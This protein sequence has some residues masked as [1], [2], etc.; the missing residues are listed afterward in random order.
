M[1]RI[2]LMLLVLGMACGAALFALWLAHGL[3]TEGMHLIVNDNEVHLPELN[4]IH[5]AAGGLALLLA[6][7]IVALVLPLT[8]LL[9]LLLPL[10]LVLGVVLLIGAAALG[11]GAVALAPL[12]LPVLLLWWLWRRSRRVAPAATPASGT[13]IDA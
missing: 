2:F 7:C 4:G 1:K 8:L 5:A 9:G 13:T 3:P 11:V 12:V 6:L 10:L